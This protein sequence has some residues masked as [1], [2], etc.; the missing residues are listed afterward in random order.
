[1]QTGAW[2]D[3]DEQGLDRHGN[4]NV[5]CRDAGT[6]RLT[7]GCAALSALVQVERHAGPAPDVEVHRPPAFAR[8]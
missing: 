5:L 2:Y 8:P 4:V 1:M 6:S 3:P 7:Q